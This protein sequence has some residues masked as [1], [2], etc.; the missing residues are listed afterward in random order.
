MLQPDPA[1]LPYGGLQYYQVHYIIEAQ[2]DENYDFLAWCEP[3]TEGHFGNKR[4][5]GVKWVGAGRF[6]V[7]LQEDA[8]LT[9]MLKEVLLNQGEIRVDPQDDHI[10]IHG[11]WVHEDRLESNE[12]MFEVADRIAM[13]IKQR[14]S[15]MGVKVK[16]N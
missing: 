6:T 8:K 16:R 1:P 14:L 10:R 5:I 4:V 11:K 3:V 13:H 12:T 15:D 7:L 2:N 9:E